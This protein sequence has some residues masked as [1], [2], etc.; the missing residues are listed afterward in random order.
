MNNGFQNKYYGFYKYIIQNS[1]FKKFAEVGIWKG[2]S[3]YNLWKLTRDREGVLI[4]G[5]DNFIDGG[6]ET[7]RECRENLKDTDVQI[8]DGDSIC[9]AEIFQDRFFDMVFIDASHKYEDVKADILAWM[10]KVKQGGIIAG[11]D[12]VESQKG[13]KRAVDEILG[14]NCIKGFYGYCWY[15]KL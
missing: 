2:K 10:P 6:K 14:G 8:I 9:V 15:K 5:I 11:H 4:Y 13:V 7:E 3:L 1:D 12:Y